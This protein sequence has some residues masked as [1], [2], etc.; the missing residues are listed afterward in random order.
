VLNWSKG[1]THKNIALFNPNIVINLSL[2]VLEM[3]GATGIEPA[4]SGFGD[5]RSTN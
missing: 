3:A 1:I 2:R 4:T 5:R